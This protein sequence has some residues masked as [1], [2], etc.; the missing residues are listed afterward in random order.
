MAGYVFSLNDFKALEEAIIN[1]VYST[2][3][4]IP[5][6]QIW[7]IPQEG[8]FAD[9]ITMKEGDNVYFFHDRKIYGIGRLVNIQ[10][11]CKF[12]NFPNSDLPSDYTFSTLKK[13]M[14]LNNDEQSL[15]HRMVCLFRGDPYFF[16]T[17]V[18]MDEVLS[19]NPEKFKMLRAF[20]KLS[21]IKIDDEENKALKDVILKN[22]EDNLQDNK[23]IF[24][25]S[26]NTH[27]RIKTLVN[28]D[29]EVN[30][31]NILF[32]ASGK[33]TRIKHEMAIEAGILD[34]ISNNKVDVFGNWDYLSHQV[35]ASPFKPIDY[36][37]KMDIF[38]YRYI[39]GFNTISK[40]LTIEIKKDVAH[41]DDINQV[42]KYVDWINQEYSFGDYNMIEAYLVAYDFSEEVIK[43]KEEVAKR[44]FVKGSRPVQSLE[45]SNLKLVK[46]SFH[47]ELRKL[48]FSLVD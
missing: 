45:W 40:Y 37:D 6:N 21:F 48:E 17:G 15:K 30:S 28:N 7:G 3:M 29:Y 12:L 16:K 10:G 4:N 24:P 41:F 33:G 18:D 20:W 9:Y 26:V 35:V 11:D 31:D 46:Y 47:P 39:P 8:T 36:M 42:M 22:N 23:N 13:R 27:D 5:S 38:G 19:S 2:I 34:Y 32:A 1:G 14:I 25:Q 43:L 44:N